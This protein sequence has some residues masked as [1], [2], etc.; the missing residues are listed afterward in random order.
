MSGWDDQARGSHV[1]QVLKDLKVRV[2]QRGCRQKRL[3]I[4]RRN[5]ELKESSEV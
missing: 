2:G 1:C 5:T 4:G 3:E